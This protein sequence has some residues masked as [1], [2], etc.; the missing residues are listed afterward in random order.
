MPGHAKRVA[1]HG[2]A[3][4]TLCFPVEAFYLGLDQTASPMLLYKYRSLTDS[5][6]R[7][8]QDIFLNSRLFLPQAQS[9]NDPNEG[10]AVID[11]QNEY[12]TWAN[13]LF[14]RNRQSDVRLCSFCATGP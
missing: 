6:F 3:W 7:Y 1:Q 13:M 2:H 14:L 12:R 8:T 10:V 11:V 5:T 4:Y 9:L